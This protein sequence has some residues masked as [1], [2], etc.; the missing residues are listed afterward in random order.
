M[1]E[2]SPYLKTVA[3]PREV[4][5]IPCRLARDKLIA[6]KVNRLKPKITKRK[7]L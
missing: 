7:P 2:G 6:E 3:V 5:D 1:N 4:R